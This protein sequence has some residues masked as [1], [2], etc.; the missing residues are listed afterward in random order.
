M[1]AALLLAA[2]L[3]LTATFPACDRGCPC[4]LE[5]GQP[6][7]PVDPAGAL[8]SVPEFVANDNSQV[9]PDCPTGSFRVPVLNNPAGQVL[10]NVTVHGDEIT[11]NLH[12]DYICVV[13]QAVT[14][15]V[16]QSVRPK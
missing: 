9:R 6:M 12:F 1:I 13:G 7:C 2:Q 3:Q 8:R 10:A 15:P 5:T 4:S 11:I 14:A 16:K